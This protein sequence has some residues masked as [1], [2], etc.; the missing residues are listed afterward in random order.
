MTRK[1]TVHY[2]SDCP[3][4]KQEQDIQ[5][6][7]GEVRLLGSVTPGYKLMSY[8]CPYSDECPYPPKSRMGYCPVVESAPKRPF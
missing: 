7:Y 4:T 6:T 8:S 3:Y 1:V 2:S 5:I